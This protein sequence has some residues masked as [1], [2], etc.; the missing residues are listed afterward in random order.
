MRNTVQLVALLIVLAS[1]FSGCCNKQTAVD[2]TIDPV[3]VTATL[4]DKDG[5]VVTSGTTSEIVL[6]GESEPEQTA[7][8][9]VATDSDRSSRFGSWDK[10]QLTF[11]SK[12]TDEV[13]GTAT[14][15]PDKPTATLNIDQSEWLRAARKVAK[16]VNDPETDEVVRF[17]EHAKIEVVVDTGYQVGARFNTANGVITVPRPGMMSE[18]GR[19]ITLLHEGYHARAHAKLAGVSNEIP[20]KLTIARN[21]QDAYRFQLR[22]TEAYFGQPY[23]DELNK[24]VEKMRK[25]FSEAKLPIGGP[26]YPLL[27]DMWDDGLD[28]VMGPV[29]SEVEENLR[30]THFWTHTFYECVRKYNQTDKKINDLELYFIISEYDK[31]G[32]L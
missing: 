30:Q 2:K 17:L 9:G 23:R 27:G 6:P 13:V 26:D 18:W 12:S 5:N 19:G 31:A 8:V 11:R 21:E 29:K 15:T 28:K 3:Q 20:D 4:Y 24:S 14:L 10:V 22:I 16:K 7:K 32:I 1:A 25:L